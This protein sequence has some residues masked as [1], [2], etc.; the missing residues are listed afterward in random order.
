MRVE[1]SESCVR[2]AS[3]EHARDAVP[4]IRPGVKDLQTKQDLKVLTHAN[5]RE[6]VYVKR[7]QWFTGKEIQTT[8]LNKTSVEKLTAEHDLKV[9]THATRKK[10]FLG[11]CWRVKEKITLGFFLTVKMLC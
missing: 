5:L 8:Y 10:L 2:R 4:A 11:D 3:D 9:L 7:L 1:E 6:S